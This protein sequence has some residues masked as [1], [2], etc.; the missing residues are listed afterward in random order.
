MATNARLTPTAALGRRLHDA[1]DALL[2]LAPEALVAKAI[3]AP[4]GSGALALIL[5]DLPAISPGTAAIDPMAASR[6]RTAQWRAG[7]LER[8]PTV[9]A[10]AMA[11]TLGLTSTEAL[12]KRDHAGTIL[13]LPTGT[14]RFVYPTWQVVDGVVVTGLAAVRRALGSPP[15]W[16]FAGQLDGLRDPAGPDN[17]TLRDLLIEGQVVQAVRAAEAL[18]I[19]GGA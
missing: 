8:T 3:A 16:T 5:A 6:A 1:I 11:T 7:Y 12:R 10:G 19:T 13:A 9:D 4:T 14:G 2:Q 18:S 17:P 15:P